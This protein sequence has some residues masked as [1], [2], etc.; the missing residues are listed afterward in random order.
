MS[1]NIID[2]SVKSRVIRDS[3][4]GITKPA[5]DRMCQRAGVIR[6]GGLIYEEIR[7]VL[8][9]Y[10]IKMLHDIVTFTEYARRKTV[11]IID[12]DAILQINGLYMGAGINKD[13]S[14]SYDI[15]RDRPRGKKSDTLKDKVVYDSD[16]NGKL[17]KKV[18]RFK[19][20]TVARRDV[21]YQ[22]KNSDKLAIPRLNFKRLVREICQDGDVQITNLRFSPD[23]MELFHLFIE[24]YLVK[25]IKQAHILAIHAKRETIM[26]IDIQLVQLLRVKG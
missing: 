13:L 16:G 5:I 8:L 21:K 19:P 9:N 1:S 22:Q 24:D 15:I 6:K 4:T 12:L 14:Q 10:M 18:H 17:V 23:F 3:I 2:K 26:P 11:Q 20:G 25:L 7:V